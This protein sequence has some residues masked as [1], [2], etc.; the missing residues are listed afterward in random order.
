MRK[1][2]EDYDRHWGFLT[3]KDK[4]ILDLGADW[5]ST[6]EYFLNHGAMKVIAVEGNVEKKYYIK[7][8]FENYDSNPKVKCIGMKIDS[9]LDFIYLIGK[10]RPDMVKVD[11]E[12]DEKY[13]LSIN[14]SFIY[15]VNEW[16]I[17]VHNLFLYDSFRTLFNKINYIVS[18]HFRR[19]VVRVLWA[20]KAGEP[21]L[22]RKVS[23][24]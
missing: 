11:I 3:F 18:S 5:G 16:A 4:V 2:K 12:N 8:L 13:L 14:P 17:E 20:R 21:L 10:Y 24:N 23:N 6:A 9:P 1:P 19:G 22:K 15:T 7:E